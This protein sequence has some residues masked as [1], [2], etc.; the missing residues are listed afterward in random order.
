MD[1]DALREKGLHPANVRQ[2]SVEDMALQLGARATL[3][4]HCGG[5]VHGMLMSLTH[6]DLDQL[7]SE[8][9]VDAYRPEPVSAV[10]SDGSSV[11]ALCFNLPYAAT[12]V[13]S[14]AEYATKLRVVA[15]RLGLPES[16]VASIG[17]N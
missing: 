14:N 4:P 5:R 1:A 7:Y 6:T 2:A 3:I 17:A 8:P 13:R 10:L 16:Y 9:S 11:A 12:E 15:R